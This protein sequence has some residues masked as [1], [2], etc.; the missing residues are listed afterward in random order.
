[1]ASPLH[2]FGLTSALVV[3][4]ASLMATTARAENEGQD[5]LDEAI[6]AK[7][8]AT[9]L[10]DLGKVIELS[11]SA[12]EKGLDES[13]QELAKNLLSSTLVQR[14]G[15]LS[16]IIVERT[17]RDWPKLRQAALADLEKA[18]KHDPKLA[19]AHLFIARLQA[20]P[21]GDMNA[22]IKAAQKAAEL[23]EEDP[24][25]RVEAIVL[26][27]NLTESPEK[28]L[29]L[30]NDALRVA[31]NNEAALRQRG[32]YFLTRGK[33]AE[34]LVDFDAVAKLDPEDAETQQARGLALAILQ[35]YDESIKA[36]SQA[37]KLAPQAALPYFH[38]ARV[39][40]Q[41]QKWKEALSDLDEA[42]KLDSDNVVVLLLRARIH[43]QVG[44]AKAAR[45]DVDEALRDRP[46]LVPALEMRAILSASDGD[47]RQAIED[48]EALLK[49]AP[50][51]TQLLSQLGMLY[52][53][54]K[55]PSKAIEKYSA[56][57][58]E[59]PAHFT[60]LRGRADAYLSVG[61]HPEA[62]A[63]FEE[64]L[65]LQP[66]DSG[67]LNNLAWVLATSPEDN[68]RDAKRAIEV[69]LDACKV[70]DYKQAHILSTLAAAYAESGDFDKAIEWSKKAIALGAEDDE[71]AEQL[72]KEL[73]SYKAKKPWREKQN[74]ETDA[75]NA[76]EKDAATEKDQSA[77][78]K[79]DEKS[80]DA[81]KPEESES[82][83]ADQS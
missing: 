11:E 67:V 27:A 64:A 6:E 83:D 23:S 69:A 22:A 8:T 3:A 63:D 30:F 4:M 15:S 14:A 65:K 52:V 24:V 49:V 28:K 37:I 61:K 17:P 31:P 1:M 42:H 18:L 74:I 51:S 70:T 19:S 50:K 76:A 38:R 20:L 40:A 72:K 25:T 46:G 29:E 79:S 10:K 77:D 35:R 68:V 82:D 54:D 16:R 58:K 55:R 5:D 26:E 53:A 12:L 21:E 73:E 78:K 41:Q 32:L 45:D 47:F 44:D 36:L 33:A 80:D 34:A 75:G 66:R 43:Q 2:R 81:K 13:N 71:T 59:D 48:M 57:L 7:L 62:V 60:S 9:D 39:Y 56:A